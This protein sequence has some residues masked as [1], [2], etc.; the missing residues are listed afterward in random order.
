[1]VVIGPGVMGLLVA[2][3]AHA[4]GAGR[5]IVVGRGTRLAKARDLG[6]E[7]VDFTKGDPVQAVREAT[8]DF[9]ADVALE[10]SG[11]PE[12]VAQGVAMVRKGGRV[13][14]IGIPLSE[15]SLPMPRT[16]L[17]EIDVV[18]VRA[19]AGEMPRAIELAATGRIRLGELITHRFSLEDFADAYVTFTERADG[20]L[21][22][23]VRPD[24]GNA[25]DGAP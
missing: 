1:V 6:Y 23:I 3:C 17:D 12:A 14:V 7:V 8:R 21:K 11:A 10:C 4:L 20:A 5:V 22:V 25:A 16:V 18:G 9:G 19:S 24:A 15:A 13:A 2:E